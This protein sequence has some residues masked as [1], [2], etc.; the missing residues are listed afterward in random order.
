[1]P[2]FAK[3]NFTPAVKA[4]QERFGS[5]SAYARKEAAAPPGVDLGPEEIEFIATRDSFYMATVNADG[6]PYMQHRG[7]PRGFLRAIDETHLAFADYLGNKQYVSMGNLETNDRVALFLMD[8][9]TQTR[10]KVYGRAR[11]V[12]ASANPGLAQALAPPD[13]Y[14]AKVERLVIIEVVA[15]D[16]NCNQHITPRYTIEEFAEESA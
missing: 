10:L 5:R 6:W 16:W 9:P 7:G 15:W 1:M 2:G 3:L 13:G 11:A 8:Y 14:R 4:L 12:D